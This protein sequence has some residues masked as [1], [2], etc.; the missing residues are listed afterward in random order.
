[1]HAIA[2]NLTLTNTS[3]NG[4][5][6]L[7]PGDVGTIGASSISW[8]AG[9]TIANGLMVTLDDNRQLN[10]SA[11]SNAADVIIDVAGYFRTT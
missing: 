5:L 6:S 11:N 7:Q 9:Q 3:S 4:W 1:V 10:A 8:T 2:I